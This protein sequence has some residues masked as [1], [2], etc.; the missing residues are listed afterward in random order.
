[1]TSVLL[2]QERAPESGADRGAPLLLLLHGWGMYRGHLF[3]LTTSYDPRFA[4]VAAQAPVRMGPGAYRWFDFTRTLDAGPII[5][6]QEEES[7]LAKLLSFIDNL[8]EARD[9]SQLY[10]LGHS[11]GATMALSVALQRP[12]RLAGCANVNGRL[13]GKRVAEAEAPNL[14]E[15]MSFYC[16]HGLHNPIVPLALG[17]RTRDLVAELGAS[18]TYREYDIGHEITPAVLSDVSTWLTAE[19]DRV[20]HG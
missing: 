3:D 20:P 6:D 5:N 13:L 9:P 2:T 15:G 10:L 1:M 19:L 11:Q 17:H 4:V 18:V 16:G 14:L 12:A 7:S 8:V